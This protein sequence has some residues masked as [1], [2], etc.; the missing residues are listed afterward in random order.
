M[1]DSAP[2]GPYSRTMLR[3]LRWSLGGDLFI[4]SEE[5]LYNASH[6][7]LPQINS[8]EFE[9]KSVDDLM[10]KIRQSIYWL[11]MHYRGASPIRKR[12]P[13]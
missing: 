5:P 12:P 7:I 9:S 2:L 8:P 4:M 11:A 1:R 6:D 10:L 13:P 3:A